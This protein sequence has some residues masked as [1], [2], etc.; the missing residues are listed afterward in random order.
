[1]SST[2]HAPVSISQKHGAWQP[3]STSRNILTTRVPD[4]LIVL[5]DRYE[6]LAVCCCA[7]MN[8]QFPSRICHG[9]DWT[10]RG[11][12]RDDE[13]PPYPQN[14]LSA[15]TSTEEYQGGDSIGGKRLSASFAR[16]APWASKTISRWNCSQKRWAVFAF[17]LDKPYAPGDYFFHRL[18]GKIRLNSS[19][20][21]CSPVMLIEMRFYFHTRSQFKTPTERIINRWLMTICACCA[22]WERHH[23]ITCWIPGGMLHYL[24]WHFK[25]RAWMVMVIPPVSDWKGR[26]PTFSL[27][28]SP[29]SATAR[30]GYG[31]DDHQ[32]GMSAWKKRSF[33][34]RGSGEERKMLRISG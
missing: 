18:P 9:G 12:G 17:K 21:R 23:R 11:R 1:M 5:G 15:F 4:L 16:S 8:A 6:T 29:I 13:H 32:H 22:E 24:S 2:I 20:A 10:T 25:I 34:R 19:L 14:E 26:S 33:L 27:S 30:A 28:P 3:W 7:A 31:S